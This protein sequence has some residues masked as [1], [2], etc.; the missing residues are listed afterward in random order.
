VLLLLAACHSSGPVDVDDDGWPAPADCDDDDP[1]VHPGANEFC[2]G[3]DDDCDGAV[4]SPEPL[5]QHVWYPD[6]D[7]DGFADATDSVPQT[8]C[9]PGAGWVV[10][11][12]DCDDADYTRF[13]G[14][15]DGCDGQDDDC[16]GSVDEDPGDRFLD[17]DGDGHGNPSKKRTTCEGTSPF[18]DDCDDTRPE[19]FPGAPELCDGLDDDCDGWGDD[20]DV[21]T[22]V[23]AWYPD[24]DR[25]GYGV[26]VGSV[27]ACLPPGDAFA[28]QAGD[29]DDLDPDTHPGAPQRCTVA[30]TDCDGLPGDAG[31]WWDPAWPYRIPLTVT[32]GG[33]GIPAEIAVD[34]RAELDAVGVSTA[35]DP[36]SLVAVVQD[37]EGAGPVALPTAFVDGLV[38]ARGGVGDPSD[39]TGDEHGLVTFVLD[40]ASPP[41]DL[42]LGGPA[43]SRTGTAT[44]STSS[45]G[46]GAATATLDRDR[47]GTI[48]AL[49]VGSTRVASQGDAREG[50][51]VER[52]GDWTPLSTA[53]TATVLAAGP[54]FSAVAFDGTYEG[55]AGAVRYAWWWFTWSGSP[56]LYG[57]VLVEADSD[58]LWDDPLDPRLAI[59]PFEAV[60]LDR[61][62]L[63]GSIADGFAVGTDGAA[64]LGFGWVT[65]P[66]DPGY[67]LCDADG[68]LAAAS[69][70]QGSAGFAPAGTRLVDHRVVAIVPFAGSSLPAGVATAA[71]SVPSVVAGAPEGE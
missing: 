69:E 4:D 20:V 61:G 67:L 41:V 45:L 40:R 6:R 63:V 5:G 19:R 25:D 26:D 1:F 29:C 65:S 59:R 42:Y 71:R 62:P 57:R 7:G 68:C 34:F 36:A 27:Q 43:V 33:A 38:A 32:G 51:G 28:A 8:G 53:P 31:G 24:A 49:S 70:G 35:F 54:V 48:D 50:N 47:A 55:S 44:G 10:Q 22:E 56:A 2:D 39:P 66:V 18:A 52:L 11:T 58:L 30:D 14:R 17:D 13:P 21:T 16:D 9:D 60:P 15:L 23:F 3:R 37:C 46:S 64:G 12:G